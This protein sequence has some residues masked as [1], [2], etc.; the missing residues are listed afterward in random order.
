VTRRIGAALRVHRRLPELLRVHLAQPLVALDRGQALVAVAEARRDLV[1]LALVVGVELV[2]PALDLEEGRLRDVDVARVDQ[3]GHLPEEEGQQQRPDVRAVDVGVG[4]DHDLVVARLREV[5]LLADAAADRGDDR[6]DLLVGEH[7][8]DAR[9]LDVDDLA[10]SGRIAWNSRFSAHL[11][12]AARGVALDEVHLAQR[13]VVPRAVGELAGRLPM[14]R[15]LFLRVRSRALR[16]ASRA[17]AALTAFSTTAFAILG[18]S[19]RKLVSSS[20]TTERTAPST[21]AVPELGLGLP[22][23]LRSR[24]FTLSTA[25]SP[26]RTSSPERVMS[27]S[28][29]LS[30]LLFC[31]YWFTTRVSADLKP[32]RC[33]PPSCVL[34]LFTNENVVSA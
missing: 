5:E 30:A 7:L 18:R 19:S 15:P 4:H 31:T 14:S 32:V 28:F 21:S 26:S 12:R 22:L 33:V 24:T 11:G 3:L 20:L 29:L 25:V 27:L 8:V 9:L 34:M 6:P 16:A 23:E 17:R 2:L 13:G 1:A 10:R